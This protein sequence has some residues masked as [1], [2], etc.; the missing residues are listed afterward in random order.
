MQKY[1]FIF[2]HKQTVL[3]VYL[4]KKIFSDFS[5]L[6][7]RSRNELLFSIPTWLVQWKQISSGLGGAI[8]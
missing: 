5:I 7:I 4:T 1:N 3:D 2:W 6:L 8:A